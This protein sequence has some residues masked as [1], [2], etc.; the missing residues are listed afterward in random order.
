MEDIDPEDDI[1]P[2]GC[3]GRTP[4]HLATMKGHLE[5]CK[6]IINKISD[7]NPIDDDKWSSLELAHWSATVMTPLRNVVSRMLSK[8]L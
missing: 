1:N 4:L 6:I 3:M 2:K 7:I 8:D 5:M